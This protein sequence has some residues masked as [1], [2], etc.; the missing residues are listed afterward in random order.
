MLAILV[1]TFHTV[2]ILFVIFGSFIKIPMILLLHVTLCVSLWVHWGYNSNVCC[3]TTLEAW[4]RG[5]DTVETIA[6]RFISPLYDISSTEYDTLCR[7]VTFVSMMY[8]MYNI[9]V[10]RDAFI[11][12]YKT[13]NPRYVMNFY[14]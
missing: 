7:V 2:L 14:T 12:W 13:G 6:H 5:K 9:Y 10:L 3:L 1:S 4:L 11:L 8:S